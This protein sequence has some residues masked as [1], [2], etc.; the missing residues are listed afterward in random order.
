[1]N[2]TIILIALLSLLVAP[3]L[4]TKLDY[5]FV[6]FADYHRAY[7]KD[8]KDLA[9]HEM[10]ERIFYN[11]LE[12]IR[13]ININPKSTWTAGIN[14]LTDRTPEEL[15]ALRGYNRD[16]AANGKKFT[17]NAE[18]FQNLYEFPEAKNWKAEGK[19]TP[20]K[21]QSLCGSCWAFSVGATLESHALIHAGKEVILSEQQLVDCVQN[22]QKCGGTGGCRGATQ[23][24][25]LDYV[26]KHG[27]TLSK[28]YKY[29]ALDRK[30][31]ENKVQSAITI[32]SFT[33]LPENDYVSLN[34]AL[35]SKGPIAISVDATMWY[36]YHSGI[37]NG[38]DGKCGSTIN[39]AVTLVGYEKCKETGQ[40]YWIVKNSW[41]KSWGEEGFIRLPREEN[42]SDVKCEVDY[43]P[44]QGSGCEGGP[45][46]IVVCG[47]CG[48]YTD[49]SYPE[50]VKVVEQQ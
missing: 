29:I 21:D 36:L 16:L 3:T 15:D 33:K 37:F 5:Q 31:K 27:L 44:D 50:G 45:T 9:E 34:E 24:L 42:A 1:M 32:D 6:T 47:F 20:V 28:N 30:C 38:E 35:I 14:E 49:S 26:T 22:P 4:G 46:Q 12:R 8:Y 10:R 13:K 7:N 39:H 43:H 11:T 17:F 18:N 25:G 48:M 40:S 41:G 2:K 23:E 19:V